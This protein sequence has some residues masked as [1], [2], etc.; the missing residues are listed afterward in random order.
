MAPR[1]VTMTWTDSA[2]E[3]MAA[4]LDYERERIAKAMAIA[5]EDVTEA[6]AIWHM[7][8][9]ECLTRG[10]R[11]GPDGEDDYEPR[12]DVLSRDMTLL[13]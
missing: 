5:P 4:Y 7:V 11:P 8:E 13:P 2:A 1:K 6:D 10:I 3:H 12:P 9:W